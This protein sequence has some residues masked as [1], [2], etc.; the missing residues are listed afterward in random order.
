M[1]QAH[2]M[3][4]QAMAKTDKSVCVI[5]YKQAFSVY[6]RAA[7]Q[8]YKAMTTQTTVKLAN[9]KQLCMSDAACVGFTVEGTARDCESAVVQ[10]LFSSGNEQSIQHE[11]E[12]YYAN[13]SDVKL[14]VGFYYINGSKKLIKIVK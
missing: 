14:S 4:R 9:I 3:T 8:E 2:K 11:A 1:A 10:V 12:W 7:H 13:C 6:L 5:T